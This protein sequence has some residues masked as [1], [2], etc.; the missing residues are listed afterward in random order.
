M[1]KSEE[2]RSPFLLGFLAALYN[3][4]YS[5]PEE[6][7]VIFFPDY[8]QKHKSVTNS[9]CVIWNSLYSDEICMGQILITNLPSLEHELYKLSYDCPGGLNACLQCCVQQE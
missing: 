6:A 4:I 8:Q 5:I 2:V 7:A 3:P 9:W 1:Q